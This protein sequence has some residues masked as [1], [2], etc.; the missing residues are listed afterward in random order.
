MISYSRETAEEKYSSQFIR[1]FHVLGR[2]DQKVKVRYGFSS[3]C[4]RSLEFMKEITGYCE[5]DGFQMGSGSPGTVYWWYRI[6]ER[7]FSF[8]VLKFYLL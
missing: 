8:V 4:K 2:G 7:I 6:K 5:D 3:F 1:F